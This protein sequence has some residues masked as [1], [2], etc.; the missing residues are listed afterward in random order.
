ML[1]NKLA[2]KWVLHFILQGY[3]VMDI[4]LE[5]ADVLVCTLVFLGVFGCECTC[6][7][8]VHKLP[9]DKSPR[10]V[11]EQVCVGLVWE[12]WDGNE[13]IPLCTWVLVCPCLK[14][15]RRIH[16]LARLV[17]KGNILLVQ[18]SCNL[19]WLTHLRFVRCLKIR[20]I[21]SESKVKH[22]L[23]EIYSNQTY[24]ISL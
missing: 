19:M 23:P 20:L 11:L 13:H 7:C 14:G 24:Q 16:F 1:T 15:K 22:L 12:R 21:I 6:L 4:K 8:V 5:C 9:T 18:S 2:F 17:L 10:E 3:V